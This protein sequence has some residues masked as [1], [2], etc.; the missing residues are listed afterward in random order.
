MKRH[1]NAVWSGDLKSGGGHLTT[2][3][4]TLD[5]QPCSFHLRFGNEDG[6]EGTNPEE[7][8]AAAHAGCFAM[9]LSG[10][11]A[12]AGHPADELRAEAVVELV[13]GTGIVARRLNREAHVPGI[14][15]EKFQAEADR[16]KQN[17][18]VSKA[19]GA[20][21]VTLEAKLVA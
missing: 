3:S 18:P 10:F 5:A 15:G 13:P 2:Q 8:I 6:T 16:A 1:A 19:L 7:L 9:Q 20:I 4:G 12:E 11:L 21:E 14:S 17:C